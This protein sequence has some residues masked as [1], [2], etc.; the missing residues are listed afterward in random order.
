MDQT[1]RFALPMLVAGQ[2]QKEWFHNEALLRA[3]ALLCATVEGPPG[4]AA[5]QP[6]RRRMLHRC[7]RRDRSLGRAGR[8]AR[9]LHGGRLATDS[10]HRGAARARPDER[11]DMA[12]AQW[13]LGMRHRSRTGNPH[14]RPNGR[15]RTPA[16]TGGTV[17]RHGDRH[18]VPSD[19]R[20]ADSGIAGTWAD[21]LSVEESR[22]RKNARKSAAFRQQKAEL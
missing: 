18:R 10:A 19:A 20:G 6:R 9:L 14:R 2:S 5:R 8:S 17:R 3:D 11:R 21:R 7:G 1:A 4:S 16:G 13:I 12:A 22:N 15:P